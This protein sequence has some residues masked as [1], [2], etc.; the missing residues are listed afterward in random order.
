MLDKK[1]MELIAYQLWRR[2]SSPVWIVVSFSNKCLCFMLT[3]LDTKISLIS[4]SP[5]AS[6][7]VYD[8]SSNTQPYF[9]P[10]W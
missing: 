10:E 2:D 7:S 3:S 8:D 5:K 9:N 1:Q 4:A 6:L